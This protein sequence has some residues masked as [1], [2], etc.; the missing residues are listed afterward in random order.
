MSLLRSRALPE[1]TVGLIIPLSAPGFHFL[2]RFASVGPGTYTVRFS[3]PVGLTQEE[4]VFTQLT[5]N[6]PLVV[7]LVAPDP[8]VVL[9]NLAV[10]TAAVFEGSGPVGGASAEVSVRDP[11]GTY[12]TFSLVDDGVEADNAAGDGLYS[13]EFEPSLPGRYA[14]VADITGTTS[15]GLSF[16]RQAA[17]FTVVP[18]RSL[19][20]GSFSDMGVDDDGNGLFDRISIEVDADTVEAGDYRL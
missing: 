2:Y 4:A 16:S 14:A 8:E 10:L 13:G 5:T 19:L 11:D 18:V 6:S 15:S 20:T 17:E 3:V 12:T 1:A 9:T 7:G